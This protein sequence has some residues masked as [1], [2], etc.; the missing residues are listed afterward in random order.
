MV[1]HVLQL[2]IFLVLVVILVAT[3]LLRIPPAP[4]GIRLGHR[5]DPQEHEAA[6]VADLVMASELHAPTSRDSPP[7]ITPVQISVCMR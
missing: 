6:H 3:T 2:T 1:T 5:D 4:S 7:Q